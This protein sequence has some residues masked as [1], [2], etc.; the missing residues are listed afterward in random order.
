MILAQGFACVPLAVPAGAETRQVT[1]AVRTLAPFVMSE[2][3]KRTGFTIELWEE[4]AK[5]KQWSTTYIDADS[6][7]A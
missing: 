5:R 2:D 7:K 6:V 1:V 3:G 4:I